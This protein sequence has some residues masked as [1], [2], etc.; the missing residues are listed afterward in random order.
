[1]TVTGPLGS[2]S[3]HGG[4]EL[5]AELRHRRTDLGVQLLSAGFAWM[6]RRRFAGLWLTGQLPSEGPVLIIANHT[7]WWD[8]PLGLLL[9]GRLTPLHGR[10]AMDAENLVRY[11]VFRWGGVFG[12]DRVAP[13]RAL[14]GLRYAAAELEDPRCALWVFPQG[15]MRHLDARPLGFE[16][17]IGVLARHR[18]GVP[19]V[20]VSF[21]YEAGGEE[22][23]EAH[24]HVGTA[25]PTRA[26][27]DWVTEAEAR[28]SA[29]MDAHRDARVRG[30]RGVEVLSG[31][32]GMD[33]WWDR[34]RGRAPRT[35]R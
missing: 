6:F 1:V 8:G 23:S 20:P 18:P 5:P 15:R 35:I 24:V 32:G 17:G 16:R 27:P 19:C 29:T 9:Q 11:P 2:A 26:S 22:R 30:E 21:R 28:L 12:L 31:G 33:R 25:F 7:S 13:R 3:G 4:A 10:M 34:L 14:A